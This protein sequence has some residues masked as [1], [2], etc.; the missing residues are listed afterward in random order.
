MVAKLSAS[1][2]K[3]GLML[4]RI[5]FVAAFVALPMASAIAEDAALKPSVAPVIDSSQTIL[6]QPGI[7]RR[8]LGAGEMD[9]LN[10]GLAHQRAGGCQP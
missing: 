4:H 6:G 8:R 10:A 9:L 2:R 3:S 7:E 1:R 5:L